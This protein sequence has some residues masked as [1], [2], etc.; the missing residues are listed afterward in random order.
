[1]PPLK[2][3]VHRSVSAQ[4]YTMCGTLPSGSGCEKGSLGYEALDMEFFA[5]NGCDH[6]MVDGARPRITVVWELSVIRIRNL[7]TGSPILA[8]PT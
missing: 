1:M 4:L 8:T 6:V 2:W 5:Q 7:R 3:V